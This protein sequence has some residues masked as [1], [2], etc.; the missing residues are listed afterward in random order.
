MYFANFLISPLQGAIL[1]MSLFI[2]VLAFYL[3][4]R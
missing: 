4:R 1:G 2:M 3:M